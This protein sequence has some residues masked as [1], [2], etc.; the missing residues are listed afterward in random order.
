MKEKQAL[1]HICIIVVSLTDKVDFML[2]PAK[3]EKRKQDMERAYQSARDATNSFIKSNTFCSTYLLKY[4]YNETRLKYND[5]GTY[6]QGHL[7][8]Y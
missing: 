6:I 5:N 4:E 3:S 2:N 1:K 8:E 7:Q